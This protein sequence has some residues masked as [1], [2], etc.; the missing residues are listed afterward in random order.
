MNEDERT[1]TD[2]LEKDQQPRRSFDDDLEREVGRWEYDRE[3]PTDAEVLGTSE[4]EK[5]KPIE[6]HVSAPVDVDSPLIV[7]LD[8]PAEG[9]LSESKLGRVLADHNLTGKQVKHLKGREVKLYYEGEWKVL[10]PE[11]EDESDGDPSKGTTET[12][13][14]ND[15]PLT[16]EAHIDAATESS[17]SNQ[18]PVPLTDELMSYG[19]M[20]L[21][22][23]I[24]V[25]GI[26]SAS[27]AITVAGFTL[28]GVIRVL[29]IGAM[30]A[31]LAPPFVIVVRRAIQSVR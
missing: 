3:N 25:V 15:T 5:G 28:E 16:G 22:F 7:E 21:I 2:E 8:L 14:E 17:S 11:H 12:K 23:A 18:Q 29:L 30:L 19:F 6:L 27:G 1:M 31:L 4:W 24:I 10:D 26:L 20:L 9:L 13:E